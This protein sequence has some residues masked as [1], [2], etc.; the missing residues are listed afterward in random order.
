MYIF[1]HKEISVVKL[2]ILLQNL[3]HQF[4]ELGFEQSIV[5]VIL[6][7]GSPQFSNHVN[8]NS[9]LALEFGANYLLVLA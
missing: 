5:K 2:S 9:F 3:K 4:N 7:V 1:S 6:F 8:W